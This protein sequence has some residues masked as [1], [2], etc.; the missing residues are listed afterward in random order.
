MNI[1]IIVVLSIFLFVLERYFG[2][3]LDVYGFNYTAI[4]IYSA[5][6]WFTG[7]FISLLLSKKMAKMAYKIVPIKKE[8]VSEL[9]IKEKIVWQTVEDLA[10]RHN[11]KMPEVGIYVSEDPNAFATWSS[12]NNSLVAVSTWLLNL[13]EKD[14]IEWVVAH[15][16]AHILNWDMVTTT[17]LQWVLNTFI[18]FAARVLSNLIASRLDEWLSPIA[19]MAVNILLQ[20]VFGLFASLIAMAYSRHREYRADAWS[21]T[22]LWKE[23]MIAWLKALKKTQNLQKID[24]TNFASMKISTK[25]TRWIRKLFSSHPD[26][27]DRISALEEMI[28]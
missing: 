13:M 24:T 9:D 11:I 22:Y 28:V 6:I 10:E 20:I 8:Q 27:D 1:A 15:E 12:K 5:V 18:I 19:Y 17:L 7:S 4:L 25:K 14:A 16:M 26:L 3:S 2:I 23:K 21:A